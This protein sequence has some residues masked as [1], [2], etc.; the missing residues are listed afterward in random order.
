MKRL[1]IASLLVVCVL[2]PVF[3]TGSGERDWPIRNITTVVSSGAG[4]GT[5]LGNR[6]MGA[7]MEGFLGTRISVVNN[8]A[9]G[10]GAAADQVFSAPHDGYMWLGFFEGIFSN[11]V[12]GSHHGTS[13]D[14]DYFILGGTPGLMSVAAD[15]PYQSAADV[16]NAMKANPGNIRLACSSVG[17]IWDI[18][19]SLLAEAADVEYRYMPYQGSNPSILALIAGE[20]DVIITGL[21]EQ[22]EFL[23]ANRLRPLA[24]I[25]LYGMR[26]PGYNHEVPPITNTVP[27]MARFLPVDQTIGFA[28]P[29]N[30]PD[31]VKA[32]ITD[33]FVRAL[34]TPSLRQYTENYYV[35]ISGAHGAA[36]KEIARKMESTLGWVLYEK[37]VAQN[38]PASFGIPRP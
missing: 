38:S 34:E 19:S 25:E 20:V 5:D 16:I 12:I 10:G 37:G 6:A 9:G 18:K 26:V 3:A 2:M 29:A 30:T 7:A 21:G 8:P 32:R 36:S 27:G 31:N 28:I 17:T 15:S 14:W 1:L 11:A 22:V 24:M 33:A 13:N 35:T 23:Q 4:G